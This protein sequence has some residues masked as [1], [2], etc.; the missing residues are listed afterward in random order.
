[1]MKDSIK[2]YY[3][4]LGMA[5]VLLASG[6]LLPYGWGFNVA[7]LLVLTSLASLLQKQVFLPLQKLSEASPGHRKSIE[8][9]VT[10]VESTSTACSDICPG[11]SALAH[12][13]SQDG[14]GVCARTGRLV[15]NLQN[16]TGNKSTPVSAVISTSPSTV[17]KTAH[18]KPAVNLKSEIGEGQNKLV[19]IKEEQGVARQRRPTQ[20]VAGRRPSGARAATM[21]V[22]WQEFQNLSDQQRSEKKRV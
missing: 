15:E 8:E 5:A 9:M 1:M 10:T 7:A 12:R 20:D 19:E 2:K 4:H 18:P 14:A 17:A 3:T 22:Y 11:M 21:S 16:Q 13:L 6:T